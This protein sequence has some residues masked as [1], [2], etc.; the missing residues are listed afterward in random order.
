MLRHDPNSGLDDGDPARL[1]ERV[2]DIDNA[3]IDNF[4]TSRMTFR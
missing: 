1:A 3:D 2:N 4:V